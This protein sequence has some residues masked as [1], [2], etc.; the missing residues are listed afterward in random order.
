VFLFCRYIFTENIFQTKRRFLA[1]G[2]C[3]PAP[4]T[5]SRQC[6]SGALLLGLRFLFGAFFGVIRFAKGDLT[7]FRK[8]KEKRKNNILK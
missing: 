6:R 7:L 8:E 2:F 3:L 4:N 1:V 5:A